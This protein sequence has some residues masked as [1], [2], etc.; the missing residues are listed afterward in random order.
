MGIAA[1]LIYSTGNTAMR[2]QAFPHAHGRVCVDEPT[3]TADM[4]YPL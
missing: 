1:A 4:H 3:L 2:V